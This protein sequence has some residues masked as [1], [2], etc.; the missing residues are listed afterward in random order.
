[1]HR[2]SSKVLIPTLFA[3]ALG[4]CS[5]LPSS[6]QTSHPGATASPPTATSASTT[7]QQINAL[8]LKAIA[9]DAKLTDATYDTGDQAISILATIEQFPTVSVGQEKVKV[10]C[11]QIQK[12]LWL[13]GIPLKQ[14]AVT[15]DGPTYGVYGDLT[16]SGYGGALLRQPTAARLDWRTLSPDTAW[17]DYNAMW[18]TYDYSN[19]S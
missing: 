18:L 6:K 14:V 4:G 9:N 1:M 15:I 16:S 11:F 19:D 17:V 10:L 8:V 13:S 3:I 2:L 5:L 12:A 7:Q